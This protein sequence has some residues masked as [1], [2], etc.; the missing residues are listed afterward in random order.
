[1]QPAGDGFTHV[2]TTDTPYYESGPQQSRPPEGT[3]RAGTRVRILEEAGSYTRVET[4]DG[5]RGYVA[6]DALAGDATAKA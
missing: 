3:L 5:I 2:V 4:E 6:S 1:M